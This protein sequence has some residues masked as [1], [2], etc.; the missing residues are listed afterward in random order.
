MSLVMKCHF[1]RCCRS[2]HSKLQTRKLLYGKSHYYQ[3]MSQFEDICFD[4]SQMIPMRLRLH[5]HQKH[6]ITWQSQWMDHYKKLI[7]FHIAISQKNCF[8]QAS[9]ISIVRRKCISKDEVRLYTLILNIYSISCFRTFKQASVA[10][11]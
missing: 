4:F 5:H 7:S 10:Q 3:K 8:T 1:F 11:W 9:L 2:L 6:H